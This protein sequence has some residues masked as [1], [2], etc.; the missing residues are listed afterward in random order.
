MPT[1]RISTIPTGSHSTADA[2]RSYVRARLRTQ[3]VN[4]LG[5][6]TNTE[7]VRPQPGGLLPAVRESHPSSTSTQI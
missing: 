6:S 5:A 3:R 2:F 4:V 7:N 1:A